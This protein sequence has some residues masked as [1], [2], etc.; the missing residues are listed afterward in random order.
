MRLVVKLERRDDE[1]IVDL[2]A[3]KE[4]V[5]KLRDDR[6]QAKDKPDR[7]MDV[8]LV[9]LRA[10]WSFEEL[11]KNRKKQLDVVDETKYLEIS[12]DFVVESRDGHV[13]AYHVE[14]AF[15]VALGND[16]EGRRR[17]K[18][19]G[20]WIEE[21]MKVRI[22]HSIT[23]VSTLLTAP[24]TLQGWPDGAPTP[25]ESDQ[26]HNGFFTTSGLKRNRQGAS[27]WMWW[28]PR[29]VMVLKRTAYADTSI[30]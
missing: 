20:K 17:A 1:P 30:D 19:M 3:S 25:P 9:R 16:V 26:R 5:Q 14:N 27:H 18:A 2:P 28:N 13:I 23:R 6:K 7:E 8:R 15:G 24:L 21:R 10:R 4:A 29:C 12:G 11:R 22:A